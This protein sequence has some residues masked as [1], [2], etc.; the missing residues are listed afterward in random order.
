MTIALTEVPVRHIQRMKERGAIWMG[1]APGETY[2][3]FFDDARNEL[4]WYEPAPDDLRYWMARKNRWDN[5][6][7]D[8]LI[9]R[10]VEGVLAGT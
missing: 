1:Q 8:R 4:G 9:L 3:Y 7:Y 10:K 6:Y 2:V 5:E